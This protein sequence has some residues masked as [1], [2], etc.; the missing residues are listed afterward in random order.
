MRCNVLS[1]ALA[2]GAACSASAFAQDQMSG[3]RFTRSTEVIAPSVMIVNGQ[4]MPVPLATVSNRTV[5]IIYDNGVGTPATGAFSTG[6]TPRWHTMDDM[7]FTPGPGAGSGQT[8]S[9][10]TMSL[11]HPANPTFPI[12]DPV[13]VRVRIWDTVNTANTPVTSDLRYDVY[14]KFNAPTTGWGTAYSVSQAIDLTTAVPAVTTTDDAIWVD[15]A[16]YRDNGTSTPTVPNT[17]FTAVFASNTG[18]IHTA[19]S[20]DPSYWRD[21]DGSGDFNVATEQ[22]GFTAPAVANYIWQ[23]KADIGA[24]TGACCKFDGTCAAGLTQTA[25]TASGGTYA[26]DNTT[27][28]AATCPTGSCC[29]PDGSCVGNMTPGGCAS[30]TGVFGGAGSVCGACPQP[31]AV[32]YNNDYAGSPPIPGLGVFATGTP[33]QFGTAAP[34]GTQWSEM[35]YNSGATCAATGIGFNGSGTFRLADNFTVPAGGWTIQ[36]AVVYVIGSAN[37]YA[38]AITG[39]TLQIWNGQPGAAG[40]SVVFGDTTTNRFASVMFTSVYR[41]GN[42][43][44][45]N[46]ETDIPVF[47][48]ALNVNATLPPGNYWLDYGIT[49]TGN[50]GVPTTVL[51]APNTPG[52]NA[53]QLVSGAWTAIVDA[54][55]NVSVNPP[56]QGCSNSPQDLAFV[57]LGTGGG[58]VCYPNCDHSTTIPFL[59]VADFTCFLQKFAA[60]DPYANCDHSTVAP[61]LNVAD[62]TCFLQKFAAGCSAP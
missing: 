56:T 22:R 58:S 41:I 19:G 49:D 50:F 47:R 46:E 61:A 35:Y 15:E 31:A 62:F 3:E 29:L 57:L 32:L 40:S 17:D 48:V 6:S 5:Q 20:S 39:G 24:A 7:S 1:L 52:A 10:M 33:D 36:Q 4:W 18:D 30:Q 26:G 37:V 27:C 11:A 55:E 23:F 34:A 16:F 59:N 54:G 2:A 14:F 8:L 21:A 43:N 53:L 60:A 38:P 9:E 12:T 25:C 51:N 42:S 45:F 44:V 28:S 13:W